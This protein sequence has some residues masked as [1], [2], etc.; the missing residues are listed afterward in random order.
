ML[1]S[2]AF[3]HRSSDP[4]EDNES[5]IAV[6]DANARNDEDRRVYFWNRDLVVPAQSA[7]FLIAAAG[8]DRKERHVR[9]VGWQKPDE[10]RLLL[11]AQGVWL[12]LGRVR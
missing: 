7:D 8:I 6:L 1:S 10:A 4:I 2:P 5:M 3:N 11:P 12:S 9:E